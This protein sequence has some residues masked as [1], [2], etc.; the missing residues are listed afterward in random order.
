MKMRLDLLGIHGISARSTLKLIGSQEIDDLEQQALSILKGH[1][2]RTYHRFCVG[3]SG[4]KDSVVVRHLTDLI[5]QN[6]RTFHTPKP[7]G[8]NSVHPET[9]K[10]LYG[11]DRPVVHLPAKFNISDYIDVQIDGTR[12]EEASRDNGRSTTFVRD[13]VDVDRKLLTPFVENGLFGISYIY[14]IYNWTDEQVWAYIIQKE[15]HVSPEYEI[16]TR[17]LAQRLK[18]ID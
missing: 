4:G 17:S 1:I 13:G 10:F 9:V 18:E 8:V 7:Y 15:L 12:I 6:I 5:D 2:G 14:P 3:H 16:D 11:L